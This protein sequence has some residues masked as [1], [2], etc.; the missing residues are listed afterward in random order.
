MCPKRLHIFQKWV[1]HIKTRK[2]VLSILV[3]SQVRSTLDFLSVATLTNSGVIG[4]NLKWRDTSSTN[5]VPLSKH[6]EPPRDLYKDVTVH[7]EK[8]PWMHWF[9]WRILWAFVVKCELINNKNSIIIKLGMWTAH[10]IT[11]A[12][13]NILQSQVLI[14][15]FNLSINSKIIKSPDTCSQKLLY[16]FQWKELPLEVCPRVSDTPCISQYLQISEAD[17]R[18]MTKLKETPGGYEENKNFCRCLK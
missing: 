13:R 8:R 6:S 16:L 12:I 5:S 7:D 14:D 17:L 9:K 1:T 2:T 15:E 18:S 10:A 3:E 11:S 4:C